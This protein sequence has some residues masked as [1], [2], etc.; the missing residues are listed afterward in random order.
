M[1]V[2][3]TGRVVE[4][5]RN[6]PDA[7]TGLRNAGPLE[8]PTSPMFLGHVLC[9]TQSDGNRRDNSP[10]TGGEVGPGKPAGRRQ[11]LVPRRAVVRQGR[12]AAGAL[13]T[14]TMT[15]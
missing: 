15:R 4:F 6:P 13:T 5:F 12:A 2:E 11:G 7:N 9:I 8:T 10:N 3:P 14:R 1:V